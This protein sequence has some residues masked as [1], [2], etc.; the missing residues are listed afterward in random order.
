MSIPQIVLPLFI[1]LLFGCTTAPK[2]DTAG[3]DQTVT[4]GSPIKEI[5]AAQGRRVQ[6]GGS[7]ISSINLRDTTQIEVLGYPLEQSGRPATNQAE[8]GRFLVLYDGYLET[9]D[10]APGRLLTVVGTLV[11]IREGTVG[12]ADYRYPLIAAEQLHLWPQ[13]EAHDYRGPQFHFGIGVG[14]G[15]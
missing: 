3:V 6:W 11:E 1:V 10:Y 14:I 12:K 5:L 4:P 15:L 7:I 13:E 9:V 8:L 2:L